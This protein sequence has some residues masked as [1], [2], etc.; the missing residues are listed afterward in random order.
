VTKRLEDWVVLEAYEE[1]RNGASYWQLAEWYGTCETIWSEAFR[2]LGLPLLGKRGRE[3]TNREV[4]AECDVRA[5]D[6]YGLYIR[7]LPGG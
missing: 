7:F 4:G 3:K 5:D 2:R 1:Y 6:P